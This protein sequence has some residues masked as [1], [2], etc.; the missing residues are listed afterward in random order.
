MVIF[1]MEEGRALQ[2]PALP[3]TFQKINVVTNSAELSRVTKNG[4]D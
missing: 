2:G 1:T 3:K 4:A